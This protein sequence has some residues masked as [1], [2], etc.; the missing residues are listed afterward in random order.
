MDRGSRGPSKLGF[1]R[2][3]PNASTTQ[4]RQRGCQQ[5]LPFSWTTLRG[6]H[7]GHPIVVMAVVNTFRQCPVA[8]NQ[9]AAIYLPFSWDT[10]VSVLY[11]KICFLGRNFFE[12]E[13]QNASPDVISTHCIMQQCD[14]SQVLT[15]FKGSRFIS[16]SHVDLDLKENNYLTFLGKKATSA[17]KPFCRD[18]HIQS[19]PNNSNETYTFMCLGRAAVLGSTKTALKFKYEI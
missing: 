11:L 12:N 3:S 17:C 8:Q 4:L 13:N 15:S 14:Q 19:A 2:P 7:C 5:C 10:S 16:S 18:I 1:I 9:S 6:K